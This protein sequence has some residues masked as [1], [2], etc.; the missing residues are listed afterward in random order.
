MPFNP[1]VAWQHI[2]LLAKGKTAHHQKNLLMA[3]WLPDGTRATN[4]S[5]NMS[6]CGHHLTNVFNNHRPIDH[7]ILQHIPACHTLW[8]LNDS[9]TWEE[10]CCAL[11]KLKNAKAAGLTG[12]SPEAFKAMSPANSLHVYEYVNQ[13]FM[14]VP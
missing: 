7:T 14:G 9:I 8:E 10:F 12:V 4:S 13:F 3:M 2:R 5:E 11:F 6:V 1:C